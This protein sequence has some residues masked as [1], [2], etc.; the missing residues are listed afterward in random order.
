M[1]ALSVLI[2]ILARVDDGDDLTPFRASTSLVGFDS[3]NAARLV[4]M[5]NGI[6]DNHQ[7]CAV[8]SSQL[9][10]PMTCCTGSRAAQHMLV[11]GK[12]SFG[13]G[14]EEKLTLNCDRTDVPVTIV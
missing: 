14:Q 2:R 9:N 7:Q 3:L 12:R 6:K 10:C 1:A 5:P 11:Q 13:S 8:S 4:M